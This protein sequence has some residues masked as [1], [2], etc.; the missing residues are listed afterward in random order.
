MTI[1]IGSI[2]A[3]F[4]PSRYINSAALFLLPNHDAS[5]ENE[6]PSARPRATFLSILQGILMYEV[7]VDTERVLPVVHLFLI[8]PVG[9]SVSSL[10]GCQLNASNLASYSIKTTRLH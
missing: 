10:P 6:S 4:G 9:P 8:R 5:M 2:K 7:S 1:L 3:S